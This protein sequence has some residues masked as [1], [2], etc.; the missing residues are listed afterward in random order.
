MERKITDT[1][2]YTPDLGIMKRENELGYMME[3]QT[4]NFKILANDV[5]SLASAKFDCCSE[6]K[7]KEHTKAFKVYLES[8]SYIDNLNYGLL[9]D[10]VDKIMINA[11]QDALNEIES[12]N[13]LYENNDD[14]VIISLDLYNYLISKYPRLECRPVFIGSVY[15]DSE[16]LRLSNNK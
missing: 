3:Q 9:F 4:K 14:V 13:G 7:D 1:K 12:V 5:I 11:N 6:F 16:Y 2:S 10:V 15:E 8:Q